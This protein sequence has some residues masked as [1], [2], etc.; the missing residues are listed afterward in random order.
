MRN[1]TQNLTADLTGIDRTVT[2]V[3]TPLVHGPI[4]RVT[5]C[6]APVYGPLTRPVAIPSHVGRP[7]QTVTRKRVTPL[8]TFTAPMRPAGQPASLGR[9]QT[10]L[11][12]HEN[13][14]Y[15]RRAVATADPQATLTRAQKRARRS[16]QH[17]ARHRRL[18]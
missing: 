3:A 7:V 12:S 16:R 5:R 10:R 6:T 17:A 13:R 2:A 15:A 14:T 11:A 18:T 4:Q 1:P 9:S 8:G